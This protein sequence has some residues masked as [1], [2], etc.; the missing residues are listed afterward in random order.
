VAK[1]IG[2]LSF[3]DGGVCQLCQV[4]RGIGQSS[5]SL[6]SLIQWVGTARTEAYR[7]ARPLTEGQKSADVKHDFTIP[8]P[9]ANQDSWRRGLNFPR[10]MQIFRLSRHQLAEGVEFPEK[11]AG[12]VSSSR[13]LAVGVPRSEAPPQSVAILNHAEECLCHFAILSEMK[14]KGC[15]SFISGFKR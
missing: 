5:P 7:Q 12:S 4:L 2:E 15:R 6:K 8:P 1:R 11:N 3:R 13:H 14:K 9:S 10:D